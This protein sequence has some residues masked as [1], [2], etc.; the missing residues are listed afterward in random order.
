[1]STPIPFTTRRIALSILVASVAWTSGCATNPVTKKRELRLVSEAQEVQ[2]GRQNYAPMQQTQGGSQNTFPAVN[3]YV[4]EVGQRLAAVSDRP[5][6]P[7]EFV[8]LNNEVPNAWALPGGKIAVNRGLLVELNNEAELAAVLSHEIVHAAARHGAKSM[9]R[10]IFMQGLLMA[11]G[12]ALEDQDYRDVIIGAAGIT[13]G[14]VGQK[15][16]RAA[17]LESDR[18]GIKYMSAAGYD[19]EAAVELQKTF[20]R[21]SEGGQSG[22]LQGLFASHPPSRERVNANRALVDAMQTKGTELKKAEFD[23]AIAELRAAEPAYDKMAK[24]YQA[25]SAKQPGQALQ[26][27][28]EAI[29]LEPRE[30]HFYGLAAKAST[31]K[32]DAD[33]ALSYLDQALA[34]NNTYFDF[35]LQR[36]LIRSRLGQTR[37]AQQDLAASTRL[38]PTAQAH[39]AL[40]LMAYNSGNAA[41]AVQHF[42]VAAGA[43]SPAGQQSLLMLTRL[44]LPSSPERYIQIRI[45]RDRQ[46]Y[47]TVTASNRSPLPVRDIRVLVNVYGPN[48]NLVTRS[49]VTFPQVVQPGQTQSAL[50]RIGKFISDEHL[51]ASVRVGIT[52][53]RIAE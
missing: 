42:R 32:N 33:G 45:L 16:S 27:A 44:E 6:L 22:W 50:T 47:L 40:G 46:G 37:L 51:A 15:Y 17:E 28:Q 30:A 4:N 26:L 24:G 29:A 19:P 31:A 36:G 14:M 13:A 7:Y 52:G 34:L 38:L 3:A 5:H 9:E 12:M 35:F 48:G 10:G 2:M 43:Q 11:G 39:T 23:A 20:V 41:Q 21:L 1:M 18:F 8:V 53:A 25:L 49:P